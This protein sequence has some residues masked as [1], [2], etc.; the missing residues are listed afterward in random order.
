MRGRRWLRAAPIGAPACGAALLG[1]ARLVPDT[2]FGLWLRLAAAT[3]VFLLPGRL[4]ARCLGQRTIAAALSW[5]VGLVGGGLA[6]AFTLGDSL[7]FTVGFVLAVGVAALVILVAGPVFPAER[8]AL[9][10]R[11]ARLAVGFAGLIFGGALW[12]IHGV[13]VGDSFM[14]LGR[15]RKLDALG[16]LSLHDV[17]EFAHGGL[18]PGYA[19]PLWHGCMAVIARLAG[20]DPTSVAQHVPSLLV[21]LALVLAYEMGWAVFRSTGLAVAV[22]LAQ[23]AFRALAPGHAGNYPN[24][25][26][27]GEGATQLILPAVVALFFAL[28]RRPSWPVALTLAAGSA[29]LALIHPT[30]ALFIA[31]PLIAFVAVRIAFECGA[32]LRRGIVALLALGLPMLLAYLWLRPIVEQSVALHLDPKGL[33]QSLHHYKPD[34]VIHSLSRYNLAPD[35]VDRFGALPIAAL[36]LMPLAFFGR[37]RRWS[38]L[39]LGGTVLILALDL[40][41]LVFPHFSN[42]VSLSQSRRAALFIPFAVAFAGGVAVLAA[43][44]RF[45]ALALALGGGIWLQL[46]YPGDF[47][48]RAA[49]H[50]P[51]WPVWIGLYGAVAALVIGAVVARLRRDPFPWL[52][53][54]RGLTVALSALL[55]V[56][57]VAVHGFSQWT[58]ST[59]VDPYALTPGLIHFLR[60]DVPARSVVFADLETSYRA[61]AFAP[62][63]V[64]AVPPA[65]AANTRPNRLADRRQAVLKFF[66]HPSLAVPRAWHASWLVLRR[67]EGKQWHAIERLGRRPVYTDGGFL[68]FRLAT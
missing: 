21:P 35:R 33:G 3:F 27:P 20:V 57:P 48:L 55:F 1:I 12:A 16:S 51:T 52:G 45:L 6:L 2:G 34:L 42:A 25:W 53:R 65:H 56:I 64:V 40:W 8:M 22:V 19:F 49:R 60:R 14:H 11:L 50:Q 54:P 58:P 68:V 17:G 41:P 39:V 18:H 24:L 37:R 30:Y 62:V 23:V 47:G 7:D 10:A 5:S 28:V 44:S 43:I 59:T 26:Q 63:Y 67:D 46:A 9:R 36:L 61:T 4:V 31:L 29:D 13:L 66:A 15:M 32:D 38:A